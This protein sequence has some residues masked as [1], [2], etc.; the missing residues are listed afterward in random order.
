VELKE[1]IIH[2]ALKLFSLKGYLNT[3]IED[4]LAQA[5]TSKGGF[6]NHFKSKD[7]LFLAVLSQAR[8]IWRSKVLHGLEQIDQPLMKV[9]KLLENYRDRYIKDTDNI[10]G[11]CVFVTLSVE[12]DDQRP[13]FAEEIGE[14]FTRTLRLLNK[15]LDQAKAAGELR[16]DVNTEAVSQLLFTTMLGA[17][18]RYGMD[19]SPDTLEKSIGTL[20]GYL[21]TL[22][23][24]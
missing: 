24:R 23:N 22:S 10:P 11:G 20:L 14:G 18:V 12:L 2:E 13:D 15:L 3:S 4:I 21:D 7:Q 6:Y 1:R 8:R 5:H 19:K 17:S 16:E 9:R